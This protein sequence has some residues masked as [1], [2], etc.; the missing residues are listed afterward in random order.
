M[1]QECGYALFCWHLLEIGMSPIQILSCRIL[2]VMSMAIH[3]PAKAIRI[4]S[5][6][7]DYSIS[8]PWLQ[9]PPSASVQV[10]TMEPITAA[11]PVLSMWPNKRK[12]D[13]EKSKLIPVEV[14]GKLPSYVNSKL[15]L[16]MHAPSMAFAPWLVL[17]TSDHLHKV[18]AI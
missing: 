14:I 5:C 18:P 11:P 12:L 4:A 15:I 7:K 10:T 17:P 2:D 1:Q 3:H 8:L 16:G 13:E 6:F 9:S